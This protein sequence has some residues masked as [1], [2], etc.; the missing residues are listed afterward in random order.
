MRELFDRLTPSPDMASNSKRTHLKYPKSLSEACKKLRCCLQSGDG[1]PT[2]HEKESYQ[3]E[4][5]LTNPSHKLH[6]PIY[7]R[8]P[9]LEWITKGIKGHFDEA[10][11]N[12]RKKPEAPLLIK[13][14]KWT[15]EMQKKIELLHL[16]GK[17]IFSRMGI[18]NSQETWS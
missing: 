7:W 3:H 1:K 5:P 18:T 17:P 16:L 10:F 12:L 13:T 6:T 9:S 2:S 15:L 14:E 4:N 8:P 11:S